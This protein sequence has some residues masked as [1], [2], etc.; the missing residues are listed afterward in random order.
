MTAHSRD[1]DGFYILPGDDDGD[2]KMAYFD[3]K[4]EFDKGKKVG[5]SELGDCYHVLFFRRGDDN[6]PVLDDNFEAVFAEPETYVK[7]LVGAEIFGCFVR[8]TENSWEWVDNYLTNTLQ[9]VTLSKL[10]N[11]ASSIAEGN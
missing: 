4:D 7:G 6:L 8:K 5:A 1:Y 3:F 9:R 10:K 2:L 11:Y